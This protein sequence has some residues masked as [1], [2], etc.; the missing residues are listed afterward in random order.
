MTEEKGVKRNDSIE[1]KVKK[2]KG[3]DIEPQRARDPKKSGQEDK[4]PDD[5]E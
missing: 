1:Q 2:E 3:Q 5:F 4:N